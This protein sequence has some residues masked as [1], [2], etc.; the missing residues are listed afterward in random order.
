FSR[1]KTWEFFELLVR[2]VSIWKRQRTTYSMAAYDPETLDLM[3]CI[4][5]IRWALERAA[6]SAGIDEMERTLTT[7]YGPNLFKCP[8]VSCQFFAEGFP[9]KLLRDQH[10][11]KH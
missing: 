3:K 1:L 8:Q 5:R 11:A 4:S 10:V 6:S 9:T 7:F 2:A